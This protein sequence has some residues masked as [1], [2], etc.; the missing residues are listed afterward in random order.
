MT[1]HPSQLWTEGEKPEVTPFQI[2]RQRGGAVL[3]QRRPDEPAAL[4]G[5][6]PTGWTVYSKLPAGVKHCHP[7]WVAVGK[8]VATDQKLTRVTIQSAW[9]AWPFPREQKP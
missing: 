8:A 5:F 7:C 4:C 3:H 1:A 6:E 9:D 2:V